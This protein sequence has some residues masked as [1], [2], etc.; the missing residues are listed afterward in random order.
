MYLPNALLSQGI[1]NRSCGVITAIEPLIYP[2]I[3]FSTPNRIKVFLFLSFSPLNSICYIKSF[4]NN[5]AQMVQMILYTAYFTLYKIQ[6]V[7]QQL[8]IQNAFALTIH[9]TQSLSLNN[10]SVNLDNTIFGP[11]QSIY[12]IK[13]RLYMGRSGKSLI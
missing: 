5:P 2:I 4:S 13:S 12:S 10:I 8:P 7:H 6:Y 9:K 3:A 1:C 11:G